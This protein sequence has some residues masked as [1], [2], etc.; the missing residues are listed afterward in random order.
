MEGGFRIETG[1]ERVE[2]SARC[3]HFLFYLLLLTGC[4]VSI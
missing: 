2:R 1:T 4:Q 3:S